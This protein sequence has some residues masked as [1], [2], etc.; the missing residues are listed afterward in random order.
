MRIRGDGPVYSKAGRR[1]VI[2]DVADLDTWLAGRK[3]RN[4]SEADP[5]AAS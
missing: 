2:Y 4:T 5:G 1:V 3:R